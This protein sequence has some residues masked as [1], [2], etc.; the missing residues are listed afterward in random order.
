MYIYSIYT[1]ERNNYGH[2]AENNIKDFMKAYRSANKRVTPKLHMLEDHI[3]AWIRRRGVGVGFHSEQGAESIHTHFNTLQRIYASTRNPTQRL[4]RVMKEHYLKNCPENR[5]R[6]PTI[7]KRET[8][9]YTDIDM[10]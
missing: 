5:A 7:K 8:I 10:T 6:I 3:V 1:Y 2:F 4:Q 9:Q